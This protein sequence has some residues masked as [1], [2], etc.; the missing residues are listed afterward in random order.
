MCGKAAQ[1]AA[2]EVA[3][4]MEQAIL[5][6]LADGLRI[7]GERLEEAHGACRGGFDVIIEDSQGEGAA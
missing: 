5:E 3:K 1:A 6:A 2:K 4:T 7:L